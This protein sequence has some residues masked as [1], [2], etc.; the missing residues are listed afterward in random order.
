MPRNARGGRTRRNGV[1]RRAFTR[2]ANVERDT[3]PTV[4]ADY[5]PTS[6][7][8]EL[9]E[10][11]LEALDGNHG[12][13]LSVIGPYGS[14]KSSAVLFLRALLSGVSSNSERALK[15]L[16]EVSPEMRR[17]VVTALRNLGQ[18][19]GGFQVACATATREPVVETLNRALITG[20]PA[21]SNARKKSDALASE[22]LKLFEQHSNRAPLLLVLDEFGKNLEYF[23][24]RT[25]EADLY[26]LQQIAERSA[27]VKG[28][29]VIFITLQHLAFEEYL[30]LST[31]QAQ[32]EW[33]KVQ[34][35]FADFSFAESPRQVR[36]LIGAALNKVAAGELS[37]HAIHNH[38]RELGQLGFQD[39]AQE[40]IE[41][42]WPLH[43]LSVIAL[44]ELCAKFAQNERTLF[45]F[46]RSDDP[47]ALPQFIKKPQL[48]D[49]ALLKLDRLFDYFVE[50]ARSQLM[51]ARGARRW[52][53]VESRINDARGRS[54]VLELAVLKT[55]GVL[56]LIT[57]GGTVRASK[58]AIEYA[59]VDDP[60][61]KPSRD[62]IAEAL[63]ALVSAG[64]ITY[65]GFADEYRIWAG[66]DF[67]LSAAF[68]RARSD[69]SQSS[70]A[71]LL[72]KYRPRLPVVAGRFSA[73]TGSIRAFECVYVD[74]V[75]PLSDLQPTDAGYDG[76][77]AFWVAATDRSPSLIVRNSGPRPVILL[78]PR[79]TS[80]LRRAAV[81]L[82]AYERVLEHS[83]QLQ[84]DW[85]ARREL[86]ERLGLTQNK[87]D[88]A[89]WEAFDR[90]SHRRLSVLGKDGADLLQP[91]RLST[92]AS[93]VAE[94]AYANC[95]SIANEVINRHSL[96]SQGASARRNLIEAMLS[97]SGQLN[98][99]FEGFGPETTIYNA[100]LKST[101]VHRIVA[102]HG[103]FSPPSTDSSLSPVWSELE[104][105]LSGTH[106]GKLSVA[107]LF[108][109]LAEPPLG[110]RQGPLPVIFAAFLLVHQEDLALYEHGTYQPNLSPEVLER[111]AKNPSNFEVRS[112]ALRQGARLAV[113]EA[114]LK[115]F[116]LPRVQ[117]GRNSTLVS[118]VRPILNTFREMPEYART[119]RRLGA[120]TISV[121]NA[122]IE[123]REPDQLLFNLLP[124][125]VGMRPVGGDVDRQEEAITLV[126]LLGNSLRELRDAFPALLTR[127]RRTMAELLAVDEEAVRAT[128]RQRSERL[129]GKASGSLSSF[130]IAAA[131]PMNPD[132]E[133]IQRIGTALVGKAPKVW[134]DDDE[135][136]FQARVRE[137]IGAMHRLEF[138]FGDATADA[139]AT[140]RVCLTLP[141]G[142]ERVFVGSEG[143]VASE[144]SALATT[145]IAE[146]TAAIG[147]SGPAHLIR[148]LIERL[149]HEQSA[150]KASA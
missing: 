24:E 136:T 15:K 126:G 117:K 4:I 121:R 41:S 49:A 108:D 101:G 74:D 89:I 11:I 115:E 137:S 145:A 12:I 53:E 23:A 148:A 75:E 97:R 13:A 60:A 43:P 127:M 88:R 47:L 28:Y 3:S 30:S 85:V 134:H 87:L 37:T 96:T 107:A 57:S 141:N 111:L 63:E 77:V 83:P 94:T 128:L 71:A 133:W 138:L 131:D 98:L 84:D 6:R 132:V 21:G 59:C 140:Y 73:R 42:A 114:A 70:A 46:L 81:E 40:L 10:R 35:R 147:P 109:R 26:I 18:S 102:G 33:A 22:A 36:K 103:H 32:R 55:I 34:G 100:L 19:G 64:L 9:L 7:T 129:I 44:P 135:T 27:S 67:D 8:L 39:I 48:L 130:L 82:A 125:A 61:D 62:R 95:P 51:A 116:R 17:R 105:A 146:A 56:N 80:D 122:L 14:G 5:V 68:E 110:V 90:E 50:S 58:P 86:T 38:S 66:S 79:S 118:V 25:G 65:R 54:S 119:T 142:S 113:I 144:I 93:A 123:A 139:S 31:P 149:T 52:L 78:E 76:V 120:S 45:T 104:V 106:F 91:G 20:R 92:V 112:F 124:E 143:D 1:R 99:G 72:H 16:G 29:P 2:S 69:V 150:T